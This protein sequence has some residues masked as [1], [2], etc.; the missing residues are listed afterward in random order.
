MADFFK[1]FENVN[2]QKKYEVTFTNPHF[3]I[4]DKTVETFV[5]RLEKMDQKLQYDSTKNGKVQNGR[6]IYIKSILTQSDINNVIG[7]FVPNYE[8]LKIQVV[9][10]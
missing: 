1:T 5:K 8:H 7:K 6:I 2:L 4:A 3:Y 10:K 9:T